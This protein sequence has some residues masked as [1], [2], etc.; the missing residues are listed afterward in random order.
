[1]AQQQAQ[2][3][4]IKAGAFGGS[5]QA[6]MDAEA[7]RNLQ[8]NL[9]NITG[10]GYAAAYDKAVN[11]FGQEED[12]NRRGQL[13]VNTYIQNVLNAQAT[14]GKEQRGI[15]G[16]GI[17]ADIRQFES[18]RDFPYQQLKFQSG[19]L[20]GLP[21]ASYETPYVQPSDYQRSAAGTRDILSVLTGL[22]DVNKSDD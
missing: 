15:E 1:M 11:L 12:R 8:Q 3:R 21:V 4:A 22:Y 16:Q 19:L 13:D 9:S 20:Q 17:A 14:G 5:R 10:K 2:S 6:I 7:D 18:E